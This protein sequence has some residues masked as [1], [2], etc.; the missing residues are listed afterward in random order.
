[1]IELKAQL[2][3]VADVRFVQTPATMPRC[4]PKNAAAKN[5]DLSRLDFVVMS[6]R[7]GDHM[8]GMS[9]LLRVNPKVRIYAPKEGFGV[10]GFDLPSAFYRKS[11]MYPAAPNSATT[12]A[13]PPGGD[14]LR[15][16]MAE[17]EH[18]ADRQDDADRPRHPP[19]LAGLRQARHARAARVVAGDRHA[20]RH[21]SHRRLLA[22][23][24][25]QAR[26]AIEGVLVV[27]AR[28]NRSR[29]ARLDRV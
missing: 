28:P 29:M 22:S 17:R 24:H 10:Y 1:M 20:R 12:T 9:Y 7:H 13:K 15:R 11:M 18:P 3:Q 4:S 2:G 26:S 27:S 16:G 19:D 8:G 14:A 23:R 5:I 6:H 25:R 21:G